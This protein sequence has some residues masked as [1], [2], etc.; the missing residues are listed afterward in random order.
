MKF[1]GHPIP[2]KDVVIYEDGDGGEKAAVRIRV[3]PLHPDFFRDSIVVE[4]VPVEHKMK[5]TNSKGKQT[6]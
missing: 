5:D 2:K 3:K 1:R 6:E 4:R